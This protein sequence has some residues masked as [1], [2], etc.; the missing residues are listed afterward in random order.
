MSVVATATISA[1][2]QSFL[3]RGGSSVTCM[4]KTNIKVAMRNPRKGSNTT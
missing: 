2:N 4:T 3:L 1:R